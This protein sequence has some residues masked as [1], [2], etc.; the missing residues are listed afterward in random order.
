VRF[1]NASPDA[2][3]VNVSITASGNPLWTS[4]PYVATA[5]GFGHGGADGACGSGI[6]AYHPVSPGPE[7]VA[8]A[9][10]SAPLIGNKGGVVAG[11]GQHVTIVLV[12]EVA[13]GNLSLLAFGEPV[14]V[15]SPGGASVSYH[16]ASPGSVAQQ[17]WTP[18]AFPISNPSGVVAFVPALSYPPT[19]V[20]AVANIAAPVPSQGIGFSIAP[21]SGG[22]GT[23]VFTPN[24]I[25][26]SNA[27]NV[28]PFANAGALQNGEQNLSLYLI[29]GPSPNFAPAIVGVFDPNG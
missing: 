13:K 17:P 8:V 25:D 19:G 16:D 27:G 10:A 4:V 5:K 7:D 2:G 22:A 14:Y 21:L 9:G 15:T 26:P 18:G 20:T 1:I 6:C 11:P 12:G 28:M 29:D 3:P 24:L 23:L